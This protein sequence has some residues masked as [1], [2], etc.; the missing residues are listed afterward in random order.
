MKDDSRHNTKTRPASTRNI[1]TKP[2]A[3][4]ADNAGDDTW[5]SLDDLDWTEDDASGLTLA[6]RGGL[7]PHEFAVEY[8]FYNFTR[9]SLEPTYPP[10]VEELRKRPSRLEEPGFAYG[11]EPEFVDRCEAHEEN[12]GWNLRHRIVDGKI[13]DTGWI[14]PDLPSP[15]RRRELEARMEELRQQVQNT[16]Y[17]ADGYPVEEEEGEEQQHMSNGKDHDDDNV[18]DFAKERAK[19]NS[20]A[21]APPGPDPNPIKEKLKNKT[22]HL[23]AA[24]ALFKIMEEEG[25][26]LKMVLD[27]KGVETMWRYD[28][29]KALW[30]IVLDEGK[31]LDR[32]LQKAITHL[33][34][35]HKSS[36][37]ILA[38]ARKLVTT[39][40]PLDP[41][42][43]VFDAHGLVPVKETLID[44]TTTPP[45]VRPICKEDYCT[46]TL[47]II[48]DP[49]AEC[50]WW[51]Q[52]LADTFADRTKKERKERIELLQDFMGAGLIDNKN[53]ALRRAMV[54]IGDSNS[55][56]SALIDVQSEM[57]TDNP[58]TTPIADLGNTHGMQSFGR[59]APW[60][61]HEAF[62]QSVWH[63]SSNAKLILGGDEFEVNPKNKAAISMC[64][65]APAIFATN[66]EPKFK[67]SSRAI[68]NR[69][70]IMRLTNIFDPEKEI[71]T[72]A[73]ARKHGCQEP[74]EFVLKTE[75][76]GIL[77]WMLI[78]AKRA[79]ENCC[80]KDTKEGKEALHDIRLDSNL[81]AGFVEECIDFDPNVRM[82]IPDFNAS[83]MSWWKENHGD[84]R[85]I[86]PEQIGR[87]LKALS[88]A[89]I[90]MDRNAFRGNKGIRY[91]C[92]VTFN[93]AG[94]AHWQNTSDALSVPGYK[95]RGDLSR[96]STD[97]KHVITDIPVDWD[98]HPA[99]IKIRTNAAREKTKTKL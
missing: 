44:P 17:D 70:I 6:E 4:D 82:P 67:E 11:F 79:M 10:N 97:F 23:A 81:A 53:K 33:G 87:A 88:H 39:D 62:D 92:G 24:E 99:I 2:P 1:K 14:N 56:K 63:I 43:I 49:A 54:I 29:K 8:Y 51:L 47:D 52:M 41:V 80:Y 30:S 71:G 96:M 38:E 3:D 94:K 16:T 31:F 42:K 37:K 58:I 98:D 73:E 28:H 5:L 26:D 68:I 27:S 74:Q 57:I 65:T 32:K 36:I 19:R 12:R 78:G 40:P 22:L 60:I 90:A 66:H 89:K 21:N 20:K 50:P 61:L 45:K 76:S 86:S 69:M 72:A 75:K 91:Y 59:R 93:D 48:Y 15:A 85:T 55:G 34:A 25:D 35:R 7:S 9:P 13:H 18:R 84:E 95:S 77:N 64:F 46:W 83:F